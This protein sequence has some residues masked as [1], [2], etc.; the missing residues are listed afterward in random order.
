VGRFNFRLEKVLEYKET[1]EELNKAEFGKA[2]KRYNDELSILDDYIDER[3]KS[4]SERDVQVKSTSISELRTYHMYL[5]SM[6][7]KINNQ[8]QIVNHTYEIA[9]D[10][11]SS[12][13]ESTKE[14]KILENLKQRDL[15]VFKYME[16]K[17]EEKITDQFVTYKSSIR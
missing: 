17:D 7:F 2:K 11:R 9:E 6:K 15:N 4:I 10:A 14:K 3:K 12:L 1:V 8:K 16:K 5:N 13:I